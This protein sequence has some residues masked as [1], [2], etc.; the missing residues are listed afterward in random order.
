VLGPD[1]RPGRHRVTLEAP[2]QQVDTDADG[3]FTF[4]VPDDRLDHMATVLVH[5]LDDAAAPIGK[6]P[7][8]GALAWRTDIAPGSQDVVIRIEDEQRTALV[9]GT[10]VVD[11]AAD[12]GRLTLVHELP[13]NRF[14]L[15][16]QIEAPKH[17]VAW[18]A[19][20]LPPGDYRL[21]LK[22][23]QI[24][25]FRLEAGEERDLGQLVLQATGMRQVAAEPHAPGRRLLTFVRPEDDELAGMLQ[26][27]LRDERGR[28]LGW[29]TPFG[30]STI[31]TIPL[32]LPTGRY[33]LQASDGNGLFAEEELVVDDL[34]D[35]VYARRVLL[36]RR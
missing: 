33:R 24:A 7:T 4:V 21:L 10:V 28:E 8:R 26:V 5:S 6:P 36:R 25:H 20:R 35:E 29:V 32:V 11:D 18:R 1:G 23:H 16:A 19:E 17:P 27:E 34:V 12:L 31:W 9:H 3:V 15:A 13:W 14:L 22:G 30:S 2:R